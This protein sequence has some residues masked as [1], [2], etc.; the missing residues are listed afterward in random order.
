MNF[1]FLQRLSFMPK[2]IMK[3]LP[4]IFPICFLPNKHLMKSSTEHTGHLNDRNHLSAGT[5]TFFI[6]VFESQFKC[7]A[8]NLQKKPNNQNRVRSTGCL[9]AL[10][11]IVR[12]ILIA[13]TSHVQM[14]YSFV[15]GELKSCLCLSTMYSHVKT[16]SLPEDVAPFQMW[17]R[18]NVG[19]HWI[20]Y[21]IKT[22]VDV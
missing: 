13:F 2:T 20:I 14:Q 11:C 3:W 21:L 9:P 8:A 4:F 5:F 18:V 16:Q 15:H 7:M 6:C 19:K 12:F 17:F 10:C 1:Q 22:T